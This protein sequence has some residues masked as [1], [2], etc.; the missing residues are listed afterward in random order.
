VQLVN[1]TY[2]EFRYHGAG[3]TNTTTRSVSS[4]GDTLPSEFVE[5][6]SLAFCNVLQRC[7]DC[8]GDGLL[9]QRIM[10]HVAS[11]SRGCLPYI[12]GGWERLVGTGKSVLPW[13]SCQS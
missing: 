4:G 9:S 11:F 7:V 13:M 5:Q 12:S 10:D 2:T 3:M 1:L 8:S 6:R